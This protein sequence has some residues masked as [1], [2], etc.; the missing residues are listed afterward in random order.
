MSAPDGT[1]HYNPVAEPA[2]MNYCLLRERIDLLRDQAGECTSTEE[3][4]SIHARLDQAAH[5]LKSIEAD[6]VQANVETYRDYDDIREKENLL[7][8]LA[9]MCSS[10]SELQFIHA[11]IDDTTW[12]MK[13][14]EEDVVQDKEANF[15]EVHHWVEAALEHESK[16]PKQGESDTALQA[17]VSA[18]DVHAAAPTANLQLLQDLAAA[19][20]KMTEGLKAVKGENSTLTATSN[21][22]IC[23]Q[24]HKNTAGT[25]SQS[26]DT[27]SAII[28]TVTLSST[29]NV[30]QVAYDAIV[31][32]D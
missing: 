5:A 6:H 32:C 4:K 27:P 19:A 25:A 21:Y 7:R 28:D 14:I 23:M 18:A 11:S 26:T 10:M 13:G 2:Q 17:G 22:A 15:E 8:R 16:K 9:Q 30:V 29:G 20:T 24:G 31:H 12:A 3:L 1:S